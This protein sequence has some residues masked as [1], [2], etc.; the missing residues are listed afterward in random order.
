LSVIVRPATNDDLAVCLRMSGACTT[1]H[2]WQ[3][4][5][6]EEEEQIAVTLS[7]VRLPRPMPAEYPR[8]PQQIREVW[9]SSDAM[10]VAAEEDGTPCG[11]VDL[12]AEPWHG[13]V[14]A[15]NVIV[16]APFRWRGIG[17]ALIGAANRWTQERRLGALMVE[18]PSQNWPA[19][20][21]F[22]KLGFTFC[23]FNDRYYSNQIAL[24]FMRRAK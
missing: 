13:I 17:S 2:V 20:C 16:D 5:Q 11:F 22:R 1:E 23:G 15:K 19:I 3:L 18:A 7:D 8:T 4:I 21:F 9:K 6:R 10:L 24:F 12:C 14:W